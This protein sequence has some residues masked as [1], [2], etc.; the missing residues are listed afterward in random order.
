MPRRRATFT[1]DGGVAFTLI[2]LLMVIAILAILAALLFP[3]VA[4]AKHRAR[5]VQCTNNE[6]QLAVT[7]VLYAQ[8]NRRL[9][10]GLVTSGGGQYPHCAVKH[11]LCKQSNRS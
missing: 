11:L 6:K 3:A 1:V 2:E 10:H 5:R 9:E 7:W 4:Q 8:D